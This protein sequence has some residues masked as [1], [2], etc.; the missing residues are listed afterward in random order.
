MQHL[1]QG[2]AYLR[3]GAYHRK[4]GNDN[5]TFEKFLT[6]GFTINLHSDLIIKKC[7][8]RKFHL[9]READPEPLFT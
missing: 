6:Y 5:Y 4:Y 1:L 9:V 2:G 8:D 7:K 3:P